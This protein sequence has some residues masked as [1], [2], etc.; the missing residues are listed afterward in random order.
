VLKRAHILKKMK[1]EKRI[2]NFAMNL[3]DNQVPE[4]AKTRDKNREI[5][6]PK[7]C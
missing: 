6:K 4:P 1:V 3:A 7:L 5:A 2:R